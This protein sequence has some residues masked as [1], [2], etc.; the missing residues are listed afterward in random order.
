MIPE[1]DV[2]IVGDSRRDVEAALAP[3]PANVKAVPAIARRGIVDLG[4]VASS[5]SR[6]GAKAFRMRS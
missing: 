6:A 1:M 5:S 2:L 4:A 3:P